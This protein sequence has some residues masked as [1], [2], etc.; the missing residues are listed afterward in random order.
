MIKKKTNEHAQG[1]Q[2]TVELMIILPLL[3][4][5]LAVSIS[6]F[7]QQMLIIDSLRYKYA[8]E[9]SAEWMAE[10]I[11]HFSTMPPGS[12]ARFT[13]PKSPETQI[14]TLANGLVE[15][16]G[17]LHYSSVRLPFLNIH[18]FTANDGNVLFASMDENNQLHVQV[19]SP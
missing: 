19:V 12:S 18:P 9:R 13:I 17:T 10:N 16:K 6:I 4:I 2:A 7:S 3:L 14:I 11:S 8:V 15:V 5:L 1:G